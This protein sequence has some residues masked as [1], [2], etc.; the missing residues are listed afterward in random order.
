M[1][2][3]ETAN[4]GPKGLG[5]WLILPIVGLVLSPIRMVYQFVTDLLPVID[6]VVWARLTDATRPGHQP[7][8]AP[9]IGFEVVANIAMFAFT[10]VLMWFFFH[11]SRRTPRLYI[12]WLA[13]LAVVQIGDS[14]LAS[15]A[16]LPMDY[17]SVRDVARSVITAA[18]W[19]PY[20]LVS[21]RVKNTFVE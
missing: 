8:L 3:T 21:K 13:L 4:D 20:F 17:E 14:A 1:S 9:L 18:I 7:M 2:Q 11:K 5:G 12:I 6:P 10:L 19:I 16:G 15:S